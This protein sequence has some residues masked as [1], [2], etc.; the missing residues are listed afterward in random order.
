MERLY[1]RLSTFYMKTRAN[2][3]IVEDK[4]ATLEML[5]DMLETLGYNIAGT[6]RSGE[7]VLRHVRYTNPDLI[8]M[9]ITLHGDQD[10]IEIAEQIRESHDIP[11]IYLTGALDNST[12]QRAKDT[13]PYGYLVKPISIHQLGIT[14]QMALH[15]HA[16]ELELRQQERWLSSTLRS[17]SDG[18][19]TTDD[20]SR[21]TFMNKV[22]EEITAWSMEEARGYPVNEVINLQDNHADSSDSLFLNPQNSKDLNAREEFLENNR[23]ETIPVEISGS[24]IEGP[25]EIPAGKVYVIR[26]ITERRQ[27][28]QQL[29]KYQ[30]QLRSLA[31]SLFLSEERERR[32]VANILHESIGQ[33][34]SMAINHLTTLLS[35]DDIGDETNFML[36]Q[37]HQLIQE[38]IDSTRSLTLEM[39]PPVLNEL[40]LHSGMHWLLD[41]TRERHQVETQLVMEQE[42]PP[43]LDTDTQIILFRALQEIIKKAVAQ[44]DS[45]RIEVK[46]SMDNGEIVIQTDIDGTDFDW[47]KS[48][49]DLDTDGEFGL[50]NIKERLEYMQGNLSVTAAPT[51]RT[52]IVMRLPVGK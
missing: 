24:P 39:S 36:N 17:I 30:D 18:V 42:A 52:R 2:I 11:V 29:L 35:K 26:D 16:L 27:A 1:L 33:M 41:Q 47:D 34:L 3:F 44:A 7:N 43:E 4:Q 12:I 49:S 9:D 48:I 19:I 50:F 8:L 13:A 15:K 20:D 10:G 40:G 25:E 22:A 46:V 38:C 23:G 6:E 32:R 51:G 37:T 45:S 28:R 21:V 14:I 31:S 5:G